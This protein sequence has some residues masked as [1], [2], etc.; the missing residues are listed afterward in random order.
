M[1]SFLVMLFLLLLGFLEEYRWWI[2][3]IFV[4]WVILSTINRNTEVMQALREDIREISQ[5]KS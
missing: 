4:L 5:R 2:L 1:I 3:G